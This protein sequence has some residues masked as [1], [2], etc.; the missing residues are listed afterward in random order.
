MEPAHGER[1]DQ[2][3]G[4]HLE[5][6]TPSVSG[7]GDAG[8][9]WKRTMLAAGDV[10]VLDLPR[11]VEREASLRRA[12]AQQAIKKV[13]YEDADILVIA[14]EAGMGEKRLSQ[15]IFPE[16]WGQEPASHYR[17]VSRSYTAVSGLVAVAKRAAAARQLQKEGAVKM[18]FR[19]LCAGR[20]TKD[21]AIQTLDSGGGSPVEEQTAIASGK[22]CRPWE[23][24]KGKQNITTVSCI[25]IFESNSHG[26]ISK[27]DLSHVGPLAR[28]QIRLHLQQIGHP[29]IG[30]AIYTRKLK[31]VNQG[32][33]MIMKCIE[34]THPT[35]GKPM[36]FRAPDPD[37]FDR[38][39]EREARFADARSAKRAK[40]T[41]EFAAEC[42]HSLTALSSSEGEATD[43]FL[44]PPPLAYQLGVQKFMGRLFKVD[45]RVLIPRASSSL[46][47]D[48][49]VRAFMGGSGSIHSDSPT[50]G[51]SCSHQSTAC[52]V[53][54]LGTG[55]GCLVISIVSELLK[56]N[57]SLVP[58]AFGVD[59]HR[60]AL[61]VVGERSLA[62]CG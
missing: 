59:L 52:R 38:I 54:D 11:I 6:G 46:L 20:I 13:Y 50:P 47:V 36:A 30:T 3:C 27:L 14:V 21:R 33:C 4:V 23:R 15:N 48:T 2:G 24:F 45:K 51:S 12:R 17:I 49:A 44:P 31:G 34:F 35:T 16:L 28:H 53:L 7:S 39:L 32:A 22:R 55:S 25:G 18:T 10:V 37:Y 56:R 61:A 43:N 57:S 8:P 40:V 62:R 41:K 42:G 5:R 19:A 1:C 60:D 29:V 26:H 58:I 9:P